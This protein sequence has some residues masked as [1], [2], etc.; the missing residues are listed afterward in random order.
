MKAKNVLFNKL[1]NKDI[2]FESNKKKIVKV[3]DKLRDYIF[4]LKIYQKKQEKY[5]Q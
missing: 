1:N 5:I 3:L 4:Q 2:E